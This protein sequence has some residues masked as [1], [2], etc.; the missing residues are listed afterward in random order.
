MNNR[1]PFIPASVFPSRAACSELVAAISKCLEIN[2]TRGR[3]ALRTNCALV[4]ET[5][6]VIERSPLQLLSSFEK[7]R[8]KWNIDSWTDSFS[9]RITFDCESATSNDDD[10][11]NTDK[12]LAIGQLEVDDRQ[13]TATSER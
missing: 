2:R 1:R 10:D 8:K 12:N 13:S 6:L 4:I 3:I 5:S 7:S 11:E 9:R